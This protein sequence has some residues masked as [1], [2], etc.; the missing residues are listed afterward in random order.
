[1]RTIVPVPNG[2]LPENDIDIGVAPGAFRPDARSP[3]RPAQPVMPVSEA[4]EIEDCDCTCWSLCENRLSGRFFVPAR[5]SARVSG[6]TSGPMFATTA[7]L[8]ALNRPCSP[9]MLGC[10]P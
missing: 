2:W 3:S 1:M 5:Y 9:V 7:S 8:P 10:R 6:S 4:C